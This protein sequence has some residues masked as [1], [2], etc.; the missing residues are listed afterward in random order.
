MLSRRQLLKTLSSMPLIGGVFGGGIVAS[1]AAAQVPAARDYFK[2]L[3]V[4]TFI[5]AAGTYTFLS[6]SL[7][8]AEVTEAIRY[9]SQDFVNLDELQDRVGERIAELLHCEAATVT[10][11]CASAITLG[12]AG[13]L[14]G[15]DEQKIERL[16]DLTGMRK[17]VIV[18]KSHRFDYEH[19]IRNCGVKLIEVV[20]RN[21]LERAINGNTAMLWFLNKMNNEGEIQDKEF[22]ELGQEYDVPTFIDCAADLPPKENLW[23]HT[24]MGFDLVCFS[25]GKGIRG[26]QSAGLL[27]GKEK[28]I[29][30]ARMNTSPRSNTIG[31]GMKVNKE[32][33]LGMLVALERYLSKDHELDWKLWETQIRLIRDSAISVAGVEAEIHVPEI[34]N[35]VPSLRIKWDQKRL[36]MSYSEFSERLRN[37]HPSIETMGG[38]DRVDVTT[39]MMRPGQERIVARRIKHVLESALKVT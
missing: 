26:P 20:T 29:R 30:A 25:G 24:E 5:N 8:P 6:A 22:V 3:G 23:R 39:W 19:A 21:E 28:F 4:R 17:E 14:T 36:G 37:G 13:I 31:R 9:A 1:S 34:A 7:M 38:E 18:Q 12:T 15:T 33:V 27:L 11:G 2:E 35:H 32:E 10:A 16:P